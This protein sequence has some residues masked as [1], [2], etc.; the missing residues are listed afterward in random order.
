MK[1]EAIIMSSDEELV[2]VE[3]PNVVYH[4]EHLCDEL[5]KTFNR[6]YDL[7]RHRKARMKLILST[8]FHVPIVFLPL[9]KN[10]T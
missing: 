7:N 3:V 4:S 5:S 2:C 1:I 10:V 8:T 9:L 6:I